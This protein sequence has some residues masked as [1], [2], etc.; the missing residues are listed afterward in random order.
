M[1]K[2]KD[3]INNELTQI[4]K[5][6][7]DPNQC[8]PGVKKFENFVSDP[9]NLNYL[10]KHR[11]A[12]HQVRSINT[13][14]VVKFAGTLSAGAYGVFQDFDISNKDSWAD[15]AHV[16]NQQSEYVKSDILSREK[17]AERNLSAERWIFI[18]DYLT[19]QG[20][21]FSAQSITQA[22]SFIEVSKLYEDKGKM[23]GLSND[24]LAKLDYLQ[25]IYKGD[26]IANKKLKGLIEATQGPKV[27]NIDSITKS[28][29]LKQS[30]S[31]TI[32]YIQKE[33]A[34]EELSVL[35]EERKNNKDESKLESIDEKIRKTIENINEYD[36]TIEAN[37]NAYSKE[38]T[39][40]FSKI[41]TARS[42]VDTANV[43]SNL[44]DNIYN[45]REINGYLDDRKKLI[46]LND[47]IVKADPTHT[48]E[49]R[50]E[51]GVLQNKITNYDDA[52]YDKSKHY[53]G[54]KNSPIEKSQIT[55]SF[56]HL[57]SP[58]QTQLNR[59]Q[60]ATQ[61]LVAGLPPPNYIPEPPKPTKDATQ[62]HVQPQKSHANQ[63][64]ERERNRYEKFNGAQLFSPLSKGDKPSNTKTEPA[65]EPAPEKST[66]TKFRI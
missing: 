36:V 55:K 47:I 52:L 32:L 13:E 50:K 6:I 62:S 21:F 42:E 60:K 10:K 4:Q 14:I 65:P 45:N 63:A 8:L 1:P 25:S 56:K 7:D 31:L 9:D 49:E 59:H 33:K 24:A 43:V 44:K 38:N 12:R 66:T 29:E 27:A 3:D 41:Y 48:T 40:S 35:Q 58:V 34:K 15:V 17:I 16:Y 19:K 28:I 5:M 54:N 53:R 11:H 2:S 22:F 26:E 23:T 39:N 30:G 20:D 18:A 46:E 51:K 61:L 37:K 64:R 57:S